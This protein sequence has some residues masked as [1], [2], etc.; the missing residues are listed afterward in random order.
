MKTY[1][2][3]RD[4]PT[5]KA[6]TT[7]REIIREV[8][9]S[10]I[11]KEYKSSNKVSIL[12]SEINDFDE[13]FEE[14]EEPTDSARWKPQR[15][16]KIW[17]LD[18]NGNTNFTY[19]DED[20]SYHLNRLE[21]GNTYRTSGECELA[22][23]RRLAEVR[24]RQTSGFKPNFKNGNGGWVVMY[25]YFERVLAIECYSFCNSGEPVRYETEEEA[26]KS[27]KENERDWKIYFGIKE[28]I[29]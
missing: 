24:L 2:L 11:L 29:K 9:G 14:M 28:E 4:M 8:D 18:E 3:L 16:D 7:F 23:E 25:D 20:D 1:K 26:L 22:R 21:F 5:V 6:G 15:G 19:F 13:W 17:Y 10:K 12:I 27:I